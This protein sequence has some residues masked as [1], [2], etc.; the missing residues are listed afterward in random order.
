M[1]VEMIIE[2]EE[3][4]EAMVEIVT[5]AMIEIGKENVTKEN[6]TIENEEEV[7]EEDTNLTGEETTDRRLKIKFKTIAMNPK[8]L[9]QANLTI[10]IIQILHSR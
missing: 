6:D 10:L 8:N 3:T 7:T 5:G 4:I 9:L 1:D 2:I